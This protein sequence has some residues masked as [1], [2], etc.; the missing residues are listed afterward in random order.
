MC[1][2]G[3]HLGS[4]VLDLL[5]H[6]AEHLGRGRHIARRKEGALAPGVALG[7][8]VEVVATIATALATTHDEGAEEVLVGA[9]ILR[10]ACVAIDAIGGRSYGLTLDRGIEA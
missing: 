6:T 4:V 1:D 3:N 10:E 8:Y 5:A 2:V 7:R 9:L